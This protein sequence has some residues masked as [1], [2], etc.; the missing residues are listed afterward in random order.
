M[1]W[2]SILHL[3]L[4]PIFFNGLYE[5]VERNNKKKNYLVIF[6]A[7]GLILSHTITTIYAFILL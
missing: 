2:E 1:Q 5:I 4:S 3:Y 7:I 6:G